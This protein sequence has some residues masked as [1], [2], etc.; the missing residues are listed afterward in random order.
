MIEDGPETI[1]DAASEGQRSSE[2]VKDGP[3]AMETTVQD[4]VRTL[5]SPVGCAKPRK[6]SESERLK[7]AGRK[8]RNTGVFHERQSQDRLSDCV[9]EDETDDRRRTTVEGRDQ[10]SLSIING[11]RAGTRY[12]TLVIAS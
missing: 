12:S 4:D 10:S 2:T 3:E 8:S 11:A 5:G 7:G 9:Q 6:S 1:K